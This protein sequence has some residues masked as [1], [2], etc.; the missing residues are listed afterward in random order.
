MDDAVLEVIGQE[1]GR[2]F[3]QGPGRGG[4][5]DYYVGAPGASLDHLLQAAYLALHLARPG[6]V[7]ILAGG[8]ATGSPRG[9]AG[10]DW[11]VARTGSVA[12]TAR[13]RGHC[14]L[15]APDVT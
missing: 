1:P 2:D 15:P 10:P 11:R 14:P 13:Y 3:L 4:D 5:L 7:V 12:I 8:I 6:E 9:R